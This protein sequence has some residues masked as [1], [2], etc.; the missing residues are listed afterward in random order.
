[1]FHDT[2]IGCEEC[3]IWQGTNPTIWEFF[4][5]FFF[6]FQSRRIYFSME[7]LVYPYLI[8]TNNNKSIEKFIR[9]NERFKKHPVYNSV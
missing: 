2:K 6:K 1:M 5:F 9:Y 8:V 7:L 3:L 4:F